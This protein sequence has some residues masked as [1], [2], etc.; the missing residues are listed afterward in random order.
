MLINSVGIILREVL[1]ASLI[2]S[3]LLALSHLNQISR[4]W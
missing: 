2:M 3:V 4:S 1:E